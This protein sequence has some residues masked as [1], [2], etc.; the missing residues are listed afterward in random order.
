MKKYFDANQKLWDAKTEVHKDSDFYDLENF[1]KGKNSLNKFE[2]NALGDVSGKTMLH[3]QCHFGQDSLSWARMGAKVTGV[4]LS[5]KAIQLAQQLNAELGL[6]AEFVTSNILELDQNLEGQ[7][8]I[9]FTSYGTICW[10]PDL[11]K[12]AAIIEHFLKPG[13]TFYM[14]DFHPIMYMFEWESQELTYPYF[15]MGAFSDMEEGTYADSDANIN[16]KEYFWQHSSSETINSLLKKNLQLV[17]F[18][19]FNESPYNCFPNMQTNENGMYFFGK[20]ELQI[21]QLFSLKMKKI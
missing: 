10:L 18:Q 9:I 14:V 13:G 2:L 17:D 6:D 15:N 1:K 3:L 19:E 4:D 5:P 11:D 16:L 21:P 12:W 7:F 20:K 8:D